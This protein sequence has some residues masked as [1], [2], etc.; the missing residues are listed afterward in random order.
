ML[1]TRGYPA[2]LGIG[3]AADTMDGSREPLDD[4][5]IS[6]HARAT[7]SL[8]ELDRSV[9]DQVHSQK[10][11]RKAPRRKVLKD[12]KIVSPTLHG[13]LDVRIRDLSASGALIE[14]PL[15]TELPSTYGFLVVSESKIYPAATR[16]RRGNRLGMEFTGPAKTVNLRK[17]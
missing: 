3:L 5:A 17:W 7:A 12:G 13:A 2:E 14:V 6:R 11:N 15:A 9:T 16:W 8:H 4:A 1:E 10:P